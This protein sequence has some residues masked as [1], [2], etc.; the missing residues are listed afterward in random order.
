[1]PR[2]AAL[3]VLLALSALALARPASAA[4]QDG[5][6]W[7]YGAGNL[8]LSPSWSLSLI[9]GMRYE[10]ARTEGPAK[11][12]YL[13]E[14][15]FGPTWSAR[16]GDFGFSVSAWYYFL[17]FPRPGLYPLAHNL[18]LV[19]TADWRYGPLDLSLRVILHNAFYAS[20]YPAGRRFGLGTVMRD[21]LQ[22]R[23][24]VAHGL[25]LLLGVEPWFGLVENPGTP[26]D[27][28]GY[29]QAGLRLNRFNAG[30]DFRLEGGLSVTPQYLFETVFD[31]RGNPAEIGHYAFVTVGY[32]F[33]AY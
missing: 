22:A 21:L 15:F 30:L 10:M 13:D 29:W 20:V 28:A 9:P 17:G 6:F 1:M 27:P 7:F 19:P 5:R 33:K 12:H 18:E 4:P 24:A 23:Y 25:S 32:S 16:A 14:L 31:A 11:G 8:Q 3:P 26:F 2:R